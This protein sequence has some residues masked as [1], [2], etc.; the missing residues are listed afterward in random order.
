MAYY[1]IGDCLDS[2]VW[3]KTLVESPHYFS[4]SNINYIESYLVGKN[5]EQKILCVHGEIMEIMSTLR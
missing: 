5:P 2:L 3:Y 4:F 1:N